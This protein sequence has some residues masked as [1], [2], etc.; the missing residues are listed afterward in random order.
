M[1]SND[2]FFIFPS[3]APVSS[4]RNVNNFSFCKGNNIRKTKICL[5]SKFTHE[6]YE[7]DGPTCRLLSWDGYKQK[8]YISLEI[9]SMA[10][11]LLLE[12]RELRHKQTYIRT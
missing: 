2:M 12:T 7:R 10:Q 8:T 6:N 11:L 9:G 1:F 4:K 5:V 3:F